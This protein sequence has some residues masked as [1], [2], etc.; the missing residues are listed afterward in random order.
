MVHCFRKRVLTEHP[1][2]DEHVVA[3]HVLA[4]L[5]LGVSQETVK[6]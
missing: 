6:L 4:R 3:L 5:C 2:L 1:G